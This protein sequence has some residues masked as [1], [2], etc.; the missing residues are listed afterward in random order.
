MRMINLICWRIKW[1]TNGHFCLSLMLSHF[2]INYMIIFFTNFTVSE[3]LN[4]ATNC[5]QICQDISQNQRSQYDLN[6]SHQ[7]L[8][9]STSGL[10]CLLSFYSY[11]L[12]LYF[13]STKLSYLL[14]FVFLLR[15]FRKK[16]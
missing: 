6:I 4:I 3:D 15:C 9:R 11:T 1:R 10:C 12:L 13:I 8:P 14:I 7:I 16:I 2:F 5:A